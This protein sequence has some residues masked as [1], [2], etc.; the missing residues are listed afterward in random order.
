MNGANGLLDARP[1]FT[2]A[3]LARRLG[4]SKAAISQLVSSGLPTLDDGRVDFGTAFEWAEKHLRERWIERFRA[5]EIRPAG[6]KNKSGAA[7]ISSLADP[8]D[9]GFMILALAILR[10]SQVIGARAII[11][12]GGTMRQAYAASTTMTLSVWC[13]IEAAGRA[14]EIELFAR[15][16]DPAIF[17]EDEADPVD[18]TDLA[19]RAG[20]PVD[21]E[22]WRAYADSLNTETDDAA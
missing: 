3:E 17:D 2:K 22:A 9:R 20:E 10:R 6:D 16:N 21:L 8:R 12:A 5:V 15:Q 18:W 19:R 1:T 11:E 14:A 13:V 7:L 4:V